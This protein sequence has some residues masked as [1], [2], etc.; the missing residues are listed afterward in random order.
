MSFEPP[1]ICIV[2]PATTIIYCTITSSNRT[3]H[4]LPQSLVAGYNQPS[5]RSLVAWFRLEWVDLR[6]TWDPNE[7]GSL[8]KTT[9]CIGEGGAGG[10]MSEIWTPD[11]ELWNMEMGLRS[12]LDDAYAIVSYDGSV[13]WSRPRHLKPACKFIGLNKFPFDE[14][15]CSMELGSWVYTGNYLRRRKRGEGYSI[16]GSQTAG[17]S[18]SEFSFVKEIPLRVRNMSI[19][20]I[21]RLPIRIG[22]CCCTM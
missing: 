7:Y 15:M 19:L 11:I 13:Y 1:G 4:Q 8:T 6:L 10:E 2:Q 14:L 5:I 3:Q 9:F 12:I 16:G 18:Y 17:E 21:R 22:R 20:R